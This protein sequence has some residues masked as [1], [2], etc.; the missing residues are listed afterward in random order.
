[1]LADGRRVK[2]VAHLDFNQRL[3]ITPEIGG[4]L[5]LPDLPDPLGIALHKVGG[6]GLAAVSNHLQRSA[7]VRPCQMLGKI[8]GD[9]HQAADAASLHHLDQLLA[10]IA[11]GRFNIG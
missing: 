3:V 10:V 11:D 4:T 7:V 2:P 8:A 6:I 5:L 9:H 1:M